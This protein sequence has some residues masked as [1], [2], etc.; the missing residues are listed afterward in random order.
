M[1]T[2]ML[3]VFI[4]TAYSQGANKALYVRAKKQLD[5]FK[6]NHSHLLKACIEA[7]TYL[8]QRGVRY[9]G[10]VGRTMVLPLL[11]KAIKPNETKEKS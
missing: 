2:K 1:N 10:I 5:A 8:E 4:D 6:N 3:D 9:K 7:R 11:D